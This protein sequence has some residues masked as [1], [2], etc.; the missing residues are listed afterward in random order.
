MHIR[1]L[2]ILPG[3]KPRFR[4]YITRV[5]SR[6]DIKWTQ[7]NVKGLQNFGKYFLWQV[8]K[9]PMRVPSLKVLSLATYIHPPMREWAS[10]DSKRVVK[11][12]SDGM[13]T[14]KHDIAHSSIFQ[15]FIQLKSHH[16][17]SDPPTL[18]SWES[19][20]SIGT[21]V[22]N[23]TTHRDSKIIKQFLLWK[24]QVTGNWK[25][26]GCLFNTSLCILPAPHKSFVFF[27]FHAS[28]L[29][30]ACSTQVF[31]FRLFN[32]SLCISPVLLNVMVRTLPPF[33][34]G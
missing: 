34:L 27:L 21:Q 1:S 16:D 2:C 23:S 24:R 15:E 13:S 4:C 28:L 32:T 5:S 17:P 6:C 31:V 20:H 33:Q 19:T 14:A 26:C 18:L 10:P 25:K 9:C 11:L 29:Y 22:K 3:S 30:F 12:L 8:M 7:K